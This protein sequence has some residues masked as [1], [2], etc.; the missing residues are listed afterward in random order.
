[1]CMGT[2]PGAQVSSSFV[3]R[4]DKARITLK[5]VGSEWSDV[6]RPRQK[7]GVGKSVR[8]EDAKKN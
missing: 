2:L 8:Q 7:D 4:L 3:V 6:L 1:M 5:N